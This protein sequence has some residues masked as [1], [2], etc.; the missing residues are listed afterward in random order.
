MSIELLPEDPGFQGGSTSV[1]FMSLFK[2]LVPGFSDLEFGL[3]MI[4]THATHIRREHCKPWDV[5]LLIET[6]VMI[7]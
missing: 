5:Y 4:C 3:F 1:L 7:V 6:I 2:I